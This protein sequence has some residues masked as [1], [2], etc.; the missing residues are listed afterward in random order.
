[1]SSAYMII[2]FKSTK[3]FTVN[4]VIGSKNKKDFF[5]NN[6][7][8]SSNIVYNNDF[9]NDI[10]NNNNNNNINSNNNNNNNNNNYIYRWARLSQG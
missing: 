1:M 8:Y 5:L 7:L 10:N 4:S 3:S 2:P 6:R 9:N